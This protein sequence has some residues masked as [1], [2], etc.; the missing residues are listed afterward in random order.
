MS[1]PLLLL[2]QCNSD[3]K[4]FVI[5]DGLVYFDSVVFKASDTTSFRRSMRE[6][7]EGEG[8]KAKS[9]Y[10]TIGCVAFFLKSKALKHTDYVRQAGSEGIQPVTRV[11]RKQLLAFLNGEI[12]DCENID[13]LAPLATPQARGKQQLVIAPSHAAAR[14]EQEQNAASAAPTTDHR[15]SAA[16]ATQALS[17]ARIAELKAKLR[18]KN[19]KPAQG[20]ETTTTLAGPETDRE[21]KEVSRFIS[22]FG[23]QYQDRKTCL[24]VPGC[25]T[26]WN[27][28]FAPYLQKL[29]V[30]ID[31]GGIKSE[32]E[33]APP[34]VNTAKKSKPDDS[35]YSRYHQEA[36]ASSDLG[37][38][39]LATYQEV[40]LQS[41]KAGSGLLP[42]SAAS[43][44]KASTRALANAAGGRLS[45]PS[46]LAG[47]LSAKKTQARTPI[48][49][50]PNISSALISM[51]NVKDVLEDLK[52]ISPQEK[53]RLG[54]RMS[55]DTVCITRKDR[56]NV[57]IT[58]RVT[59]NPSRLSKDDWP[60][61]VAAFVQG[62]TWQ[63]KG[64]PW[65]SP[66]E[67]FNNV[68][69]FYLKWDDQATDK[70]VAKWNVQVI[71]LSRN[72]RHLDKAAVLKFWNSI[73]QDVVKMRPLPKV[74]GI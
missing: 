14:D 19:V 38:D 55:S 64:W 31:G 32:L 29:K 39:V 36:F 4:L 53:A 12:A 43:V 65:T 51:S 73:E 69:G 16:L 23:R 20:E 27:Q 28:A 9:D 66:A 34:V 59:N 48:V 54:V 41:I 1:D 5:R 74:N 37:F 67:I 42:S 56:N 6:E 15:P 72:K 11:D 61:V 52:F 46:A 7:G 49:I 63:F 33:P 3:K 50:I 25:D 30:A 10:Y 18:R 2:R 44:S 47:A 68:R 57:P 24:H 62:Q 26:D 21:H 60:C 71:E 8:E 17:D 70:N 45:H 22:K 35:G 13:K 58:L 40:P